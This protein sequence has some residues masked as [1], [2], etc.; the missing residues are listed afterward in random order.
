[1]SRPVSASEA[2]SAISGAALLAAR[3]GRPDNALTAL[4]EVAGVA[5]V[6]R[7]VIGPAWRALLRI[8]TR[9]RTIHLHASL[10]I[11]FPVHETFEFFT[12]FENFPRVTGML[13]SVVD[14][15]DG[16]S[17]WELVSPSG[18]IIAWDAVITKYVPH[19]VIAWESLPGAEARNTGLLRFSPTP[20]G[21]TRLDISVDYEP[22]LTGWPDALRALLDI[23]RQNRLRADLERLEFYFHSLPPTPEPGE[24]GEQGTESAGTESA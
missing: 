22:V 6:G 11:D 23:P 1:M 24:P 12:D 16:R 15:Q 9:R 19:S 5:L 7:G 3:R 21:G 13:H 20:E 17:H 14:Y 4:L 8:G 10:R 18:E 2:V